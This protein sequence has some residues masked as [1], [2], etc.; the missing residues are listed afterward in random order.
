MKALLEGK[1]LGIAGSNTDPYL[2]SMKWHKTTHIHCELH[3]Y[4]NNKKIPT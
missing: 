2:L 4:N 1:G 3:A